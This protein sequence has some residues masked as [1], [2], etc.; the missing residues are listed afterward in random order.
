M[1]IKFNSQN[2]PEFVRED[3][4]IA[5]YA[6]NN[7]QKGW[8]V[9]INSDGEEQSIVDGDYLIYNGKFYQVITQAE[10]QADFLLQNEIQEY[11]GKNLVRELFKELRNQN[12]TQ[13]NEADIVTRIQTTLTALATGF[14]KGARTIA[15][16]TATGGAFTAA[17]KTYLLNQI[18]NV[19]TQL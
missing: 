12:L 9:K 11:Y 2:K 6:T 19:I 15:N 16:N 17:R 18:D 8:W 10:Y 7:F 1:I 4:M 5:D 14:V 3:W 13:A